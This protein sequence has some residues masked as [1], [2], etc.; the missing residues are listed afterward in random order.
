MN[1]FLSDPDMKEVVDDFCQESRKILA[2]LEDILDD[3]EDDTTQTALLEKYGQS[4][5]RIMGAAKTVGA[6][7]V[8][9]YAELGKTIGYKSSQVK[10]NDQLIDIVVSTL[11][12]TNEYIGKMIEH[13]DKN[14]NEDI[15]GVN[16]D[17]FSSR[18]KWL[19][20]KFDHINR[21]SVAVNDE[22]KDQNDID[23][24]LKQL[25]L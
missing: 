11:F 17:A 3:F 16:L 15:S 24:L 21:S 25:G 7:K 5:D 8:G 20:G 4:V 22:T 10:D 23:D 6:D 19:A 1:D 18:L 14:R 2:E 13:I 12:D 9:L